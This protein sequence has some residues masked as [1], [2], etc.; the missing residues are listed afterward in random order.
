M[1]LCIK[2][3][4]HIFNRLY[5][6]KLHLRIFEDINDKIKFLINFFNSIL[7]HFLSILK[8]VRSLFLY[9]YY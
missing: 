8:I 7:S 6:L 4:M 9:N 1:H 3:F 5:T 2:I